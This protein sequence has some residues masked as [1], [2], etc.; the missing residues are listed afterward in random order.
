[1][2][3]NDTNLIQDIYSQHLKVING[4][5]LTRREIDIITFFVCGRSVKKAAS[6]FSI[7]PKTVENHSHNI[8][9]KLGCNSRE[10]I[11]DFIERS[12]KL[13]LLRN[14]YTAMLAQAV[15]NKSLREVAKLSKEVSFSCSIINDLEQ[16]GQGCLGD[17]LKAALSL[18]GIT[19]SIDVRKS[20]DSIDKSHKNSFILHIA[21]FNSPIQTGEMQE[22]ALLSHNKNCVLLLMPAE[23]GPVKV[24][25][26]YVDVNCLDQGDQKNYYFLVFEILNKIIS[27]SN[28]NSIYLEFK[29]QFHVMEDFVDPKDPLPPLEARKLANGEINYTPIRNSN[30]HHKKWYSLLVVFL[31]SFVIMGVLHFKKNGERSKDENWIQTASTEEVQDNK[32]RISIRSDLEVPTQSVILNRPELTTQINDRF[33]D[34]SGIQTIALIGMGGAGKTTLARMYMSEQNVQVLWEINA[35]TKETLN[36]SFESFAQALSTTEKDQKILRGI[37]KIKNSMDR[38]EKVVQFVKEKLRIHSN[39]FLIYDNVKQ[40]TDIQKYFPKDPGKWGQGRIILTTQDSNI[41]NNNYVDSSVVVNELNSEQKLNLFIKI[42][43][44]GGALTFSPAQVNEAKNFLIE[45]PPFPLDV[46][47]AAYY[48]KTTHVSYKNYLENMLKYN[49]DFLNVQKTILQEAGDYSKTRYG[50][51]TL[52]LKHLIDTNPDFKD[53]LLFISLLDSQN[54]PRDLLIK[55]KDAHVVDSFVY[56][57]KKHSLITN[58]ISTAYHL[59]LGF[60]IH[61]STQAIILAY[62]TKTVDL[63]QNQNSTQAIANILGIYMSDVVDKEDF[64]KMKSLYRHVEQFLSHNNL[65]NDKNTGSISGELGCIYY[66]LRNS[67]KARK[68][69]IDGLA[70]LKQCDHEN[71]NKIAHFLVYLGNVSRGLGDYEKAKELFEQSFVIYKK[72]V[73]DHIGLARASGYLG[74]VH[75]GLG[76]FAEAKVLLERSRVIYEKYPENGVGLARSL[77]HLGSVHKNL[78]EYETAR[79]L[80]EKSLTIYKKYS[81]KH[82]GAAWVCGNLGNVYLKLGDYK[83]AKELLD[84][85]LAICSEHFLEDHV[86]V[87]RALVHL[88]VYYRE[89]GHYEKA[90]ELLNKNLIVFENTYGKNHVEAGFVLKH[91]AEVYLQEGNLEAAEK[92]IGEALNIFCKNR[93]PDKY[94]ALEILGEIYLKK[95]INAKNRRDIQYSQ[96]LQLQAVSYLGQALDVV[97][98][99]FPTDS[100]HRQRIQTKFE[101]FS[102][103]NI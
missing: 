79:D 63:Q 21:P 78:G 24:L 15:F 29:K 9:L 95:S 74:V 56:H 64:T 58:E 2:Q 22:S 57:L 45:I 38:E 90:K 37:L 85:S 69:L 101:K 93:Y 32:E 94:V 7:S 40:F 97:K 3:N 71:H 99:H 83:K 33:K 4:I 18:A 49:M 10:S 77:A 62:L 89:Q 19:V 82:V 61:R 87:A 26:E 48:L 30:K 96:H 46:S 23:K 53:L 28:F 17:Y 39:W 27:D 102:T 52:S 55:Y 54:I 81:E 12:D 60:S 50:I 98:I 70:K 35:E 100:P 59:D 66:Y 14:Y 73:E 44:N 42:M 36:A 8:M 5:K 103:G 47:V 80:F 11:I 51:I 75:N 88:G 25:E 92:I 6:F 91:L 68:L 76:N 84:E 1:M 41:E 31:L 13:P 67:T 72:N 16:D 43:N 20:F 34:R 86:F 65:L